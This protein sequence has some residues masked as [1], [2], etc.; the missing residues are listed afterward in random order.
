[1]E[2]PRQR[3]IISLENWNVLVGEKVVWREG[4]YSAQSHFLLPEAAS[5]KIKNNGPSLFYVVLKMG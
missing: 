5:Y 3:R 2:G 1:M 4:L